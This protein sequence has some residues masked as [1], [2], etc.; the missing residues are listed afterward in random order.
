MCLEDILRNN[1]EKL[2]NND[3]NDDNINSYF[4]FSAYSAPRNY[5]KCFYTYYLI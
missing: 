2:S 1:P 5:A 3:A 4:F